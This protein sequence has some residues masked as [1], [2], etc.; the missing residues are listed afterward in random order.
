MH[1]KK[2]S[3]RKDKMEHT[4]ESPGALLP[5]WEQPG[6]HNKQEKETTTDLGIASEE[7][8][9]CFLCFLKQSVHSVSKSLTQLQLS[10]LM[11]WSWW[12][13][14]LF[15]CS[16]SLLI[17]RG[18]MDFCQYPYK[19]HLQWSKEGWRWCWLA[20]ER[21]WQAIQPTL[22]FQADRA[23]GCIPFAPDHTTTGKILFFGWSLL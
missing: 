18:Q 3:L 4:R 16:N 8:F 6:V 2:T 22:H 23:A 14:S 1:Y 5:G 17:L 11:P 21:L 12:A 19:A 20:T 10:H 13:A 15:H 7:V 9:L